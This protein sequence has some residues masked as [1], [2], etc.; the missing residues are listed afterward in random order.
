[1]LLRRLLRKEFDTRPVASTPGL[2]GG[3]GGNRLD[4][5]GKD[6]DRKKLLPLCERGGQFLP[7]PL[8][9]LATPPWFLLPLRPCSYHTQESMRA[10][11]YSAG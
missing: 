6:D 2:V 10:N 11:R 3:G 8:A 1:M 7:T 9:A 4:R 5:R